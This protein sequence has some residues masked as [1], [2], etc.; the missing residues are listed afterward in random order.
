[1][2]L[3]PLSG[4]HAGAFSR[5]TTQ[6]SAVNGELFT[7]EKGRGAKSDSLRNRDTPTSAS[8]E[9]LLKHRL[10]MIEQ[11]LTYNELRL[12]FLLVVACLGAYLLFL[13]HMRHPP[14]TTI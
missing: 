12:R 7:P 5:K 9:K 8:V 13:T 4:R 14:I 10:K 6:S 1:M 2:E 3:K 11:R